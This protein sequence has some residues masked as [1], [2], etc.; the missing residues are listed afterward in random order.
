MSPWNEATSGLSPVDR[1]GVRMNARLTDEF[2][3]VAPWGVADR[4]RAMLEHHCMPDAAYPEGVICSLYY[5]SPSFHCLLEK[6]NGDFLKHKLRLRWY[7]PQ[8]LQHASTGNAFL[9]VKSKVGRGR[10]KERK[11]LEFDGAWLC[12]TS[13]DDP[14]FERLPQEHGLQLGELVHSA[15]LPV[16]VIQYHRLRYVCPRTLARVSLD[17]HIE[18]QRTNP[19]ILPWHG[20]CALR[21]VVMEIKGAEL[22]DVV[23]LSDMHAL[24][25]RYGSFSKY[26]ECLLPIVM[27]AG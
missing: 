6:E 9:E 14:V 25:F 15:L 17:T 2:K 20:G 10:R 12:N 7:D 23:W 24:G 3:F 1:W 16:A 5:D 26:G 19:R 22:H 18:I 8:R 27:G 4:G 13:L 21:R 11:R